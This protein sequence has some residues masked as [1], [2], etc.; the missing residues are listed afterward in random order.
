MAQSKWFGLRASTI[1]SEGC[2]KSAISSFCSNFVAFLRAF[3]NWDQCF[4]CLLR[5]WLL[6]WA[7]LWYLESQNICGHLKRFSLACS[8]SWATSSKWVRNFLL[9][10]EHCKWLSVT[11]LS[12]SWRF[13]ETSEV[14]E[15]SSQ[16]RPIQFGIFGRVT[17]SEDSSKFEFDMSFSRMFS[18][19][20]GISISTSSSSESF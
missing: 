18:K 5:I 17:Y 1:D 13:C 11:P 9:Q 8:S 7:A 6:R 14:M 10:W 12:Q 2:I 4:W 3:S 16:S 15:T 19:P 20:P